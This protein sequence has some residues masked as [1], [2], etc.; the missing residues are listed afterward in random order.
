[1]VCY[2]TVYFQVL[3]LRIVTMTIVTMM[4]KVKIGRRSFWTALH[5]C[6]ILLLN[7]VDLYMIVRLDCTMMYKLE[8][9]M[10]KY[11]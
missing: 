1:M 11:V 8:C 3:L 5:K 10:I 2:K 9:I 7:R 6:L 4:R